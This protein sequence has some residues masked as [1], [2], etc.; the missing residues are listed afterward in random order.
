MPDR[1]NLF[2]VS[3][4]SSLIYQD[5]NE[6]KTKYLMPLQAGVVG[7][8]TPNDSLMWCPD[9]NTISDHHLT[10]LREQVRVSSRGK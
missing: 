4:R 9:E 8:G 7:A 3:K 10:K 2:G 1:P 5:T 6:E